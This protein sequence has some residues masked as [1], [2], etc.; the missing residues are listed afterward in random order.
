MANPTAALLLPGGPTKGWY[1]GAATSSAT[2][3]AIAPLSA[4]R[5]ASAAQPAVASS[6]ATHRG[7]VRELDEDAAPHGLRAAADGIGGSDAEIALVIEL[8]AR[9][10][11]VNHL[12]QM[13]L[14]RGAPDEI[15][16]AAI[17]VANTEPTYR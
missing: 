6:A 5:M 4:A 8:R 15:S 7:L 14:D 2:R 1:L 16:A 9:R 12:I 3:P 13:A 17:E 11:A 10:E